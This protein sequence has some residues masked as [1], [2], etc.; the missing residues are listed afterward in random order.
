G[1][2]DGLSGE[3]IPLSSRIV[4]VC[5]AFQDTTS[6]RPYRATLTVE[7]G[8]AQLRGAAATQFDPDVVRVFDEVFEGVVDGGRLPTAAPA[9]RH[10]RVLV[11]DDDPA[12]RFLL[13]RSVEAAGHE[14]M[15][16]A[17]GNEALET[18]RREL[19]DIVLCDARLPGI[20][21]HELCR[22]I[23]AEPQAP[24]TY[25]VMLTA[26]GDLG[27]A[28]SDG[29]AGADNFLTKPI[30]RDELDSRLLAAARSA[31]THDHATGAG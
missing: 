27:L 7:E 25:F 23:R 3:Q 8:L 31:L 1:Y 4:F 15:T 21:G 10:L 17:S 12:S 14:C 29:G 19:P 20:D 13:W 18:F 30:A 9:P 6:A 22:L 26:L 2:P 24:H 28:R 11:A 5:T 16:V